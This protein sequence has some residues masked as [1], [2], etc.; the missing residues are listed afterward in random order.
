VK[1]SGGAR[2]GH[3]KCMTDPGGCRTASFRARS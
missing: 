2:L 1:G 3:V